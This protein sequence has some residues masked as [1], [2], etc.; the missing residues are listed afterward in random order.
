MTDDL[1]ALRAELDDVDRAVIALLARRARLVG[2]AWALKD[3]TGSP[4]RDHAR[5]RAI[6]ERLLA[7]AEADGLDSGRVRAVLDHI[8]GVD[9]RRRG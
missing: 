5:E 1:A 4:L 7:L 6:F 3:A 8:V 2:R 9:L